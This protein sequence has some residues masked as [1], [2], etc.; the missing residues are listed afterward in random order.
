MKEPSV[1]DY[2][3]SK[4]FPWRGEKIV[5]PPPDAEPV[6]LSINPVEIEPLVGMETT[7]DVTKAPAPIPAAVKVEWSFPWRSLAALAMALAAQF[8]LEPPQ[9]DTTFAIGLY[10]IAAALLVWAILSKEWPIIPLRPDRPETVSLSFGRMAGLAVIPL[11]IFAFLMFGGNRFSELNLAAWALL[12]GYALVVFWLRRPPGMKGPKFSFLSGIQFNL[13]IN[14][15]PVLLFLTVILILFFRFYRLDQVPGEMF[16]DHAEKLLD[17]SNVLNGQTSIFFP[18]NTG[19]EAIQMYLTAAIALLGSGLSFMSLKIGTALCGVL[20]LPFVYLL[21]KEL[22]GRWVGYFALV[23]VG[24]AY[25]PNLI[26]RIGLRFPLYPLFVAPVFYYLIRGLR[27][28]SR[29]D[30]ILAGIFLG[31]GLQGYSPMRIV[32]FVIVLLVALY[33]LHGQARGKRVATIGALAL[34]ALMS[35][36]LF[37]PLGRY[38]LDNP[39]RFALRAFTRLAPIETQLPAPALQIFLDNLWKAWV[40]PF[41]DNGGIWVHSVVGRPALDL[42]AAALYFI[43]SVYVFIRYIKQRS[44]IDLFLLVSVP[45]FMMPS[46]LSLAFPGENPS[47]NRTGG[48]IIPIF[49]LCAIGLEGILG[50]FTRKVRSLPGQLTAAVLGVIILAWSAGASYNLVFNKFD[51][52]FMAGAWNTS[53]IGSVI[54]GFVNSMGTPDSAYV[55]PFPYWVDTR[56]VGINAGFPNKDFAINRDQ[57]SETLTSPLAK[58]FIYKADDQES[59]NALRTLYPE[60]WTILQKSTYEGKDFYEYVVPPRQDL[61]K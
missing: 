43:G 39:D 11:M 36:L 19:R 58:L 59:F 52:Q 4:L 30:F 25:W 35:F 2:V 34:L 10:A 49:I 48:A 24:V 16:S 41:W 29:N 54:R 18:R 28:S 60:G 56:L 40:M 17:V 53:Q 31:L 51:Q 22:G 44:W 8:N 20:T 3:L 15:W 33:L 50:G 61:L 1:L 47:L 5:I 37:L 55:I 13:K 32:P 38:A 14:Y 6:E 9:R 42:V 45:L 57:L 27:N 12:I 23:L 26:A 46:I 21:G 7:P